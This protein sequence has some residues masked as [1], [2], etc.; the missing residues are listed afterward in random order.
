MCAIGTFMTIQAFAQSGADLES[1]L[2][3]DQMLK[4]QYHDQWFAKQDVDLASGQEEGWATSI[5]RKNGKRSDEY[6]KGNRLS[7]RVKPGRQPQ[8]G[9]CV[10]PMKEPH[11]VILGTEDCQYGSE[12]AWFKNRAMKKD[13]ECIWTNQRSPSL[14]VFY[15]SERGEKL[16][17][18]SAPQKWFGGQVCDGPVLH[19]DTMSLLLKLSAM[20][21]SMSADGQRIVELVNRKAELLRTT[22]VKEIAELLSKQDLD[23]IAAKVARAVSD[24]IL[25]TLRKQGRIE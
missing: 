9:Y 23:D 21:K 4:F 2:T 14:R 10:S 3:D 20:N 6:L 25:A 15:F 12:Q 18:V 13:I 19:Q 11:I 1:W 17:N 8:R 5:Q 22:M 24:E 16:V 7:L